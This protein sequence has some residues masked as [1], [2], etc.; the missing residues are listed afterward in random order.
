MVRL[1]V[2]IITRNEELNLAR[3]L[4]SV[5]F[6][7]EVVIA[8][9]HSTDRTVEIAH[10]F[11]A[12]IFEIDWPGF[13]PAKQAAL[14]RAT[15]DWVL[16]IDADEE[17]SSSLAEE[18]RAVVSDG[19]GR[20]GYLIPRRANFLGRWIK[21]CGWYPDPLLRLFQRT[22]GRF[23]QAVV[24]ERVIVDG[25][26]GRLKSELLHYSYPDLETYFEKSNRYTTVGAAELARAGVQASASDIVI[27]PV[28]AF[29]KHYISK[30]GF[31]DGLEG[32]LVSV[33]S[34][35]AVMVKYAKLRRLN[36]RADALNGK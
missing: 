3:C 27:R 29:I 8:D 33:F 21:H 15:G 31:L 12:S 34:A 14:D 30:L 28:I 5:S 25:P 6:A 24:H 36:R 1:S 9:S 18:I 11:G 22:S 35:Q 23:D 7:D 17:V 2:V 10:Q 13:G 26:V 32:F 4:K 20:A 19:A 16:S